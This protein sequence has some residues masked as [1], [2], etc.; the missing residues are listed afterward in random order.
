MNLI[1]RLEKVGRL[2]LWLCLSAC[3]VLVPVGLYAQEKQT[4]LAA[5][6][7]HADAERLRL[8]AERD[9]ATKQKESERGLVS[10]H[11]LGGVLQGL[12]GH[13]GAVWFSNISPTPGVVCVRATMTNAKTGQV[14]RSLPGCL[15][16]APYA[17]N[18]M[19]KLMFAGGSLDEACPQA[20]AC[21][22]TI[23]DV[24]FREA[25]AK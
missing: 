2:V 20:G 18:A 6:R 22:L 3:L 12:D 25:N 24:P 21:K 23:D 7:A 1:D 10:I 13:M 9:A 15:E 14:E 4:A 11:A 5:D 8:D 16:V 17:S 19:L